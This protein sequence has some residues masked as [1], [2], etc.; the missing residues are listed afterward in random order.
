MPNFTIPSRLPGAPAVLNQMTFV[1][2][3]AFGNLDSKF[4]KVYPRF[5]KNASVLVLLKK[6]FYPQFF[7]EYFYKN[8]H[9]LGIKLLYWIGRHSFDLYYLIYAWIKFDA[10]IMRFARLGASQI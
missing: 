8:I 3:Y 9:N 2:K 5:S 1:K 7:F 10:I 6:K 4:K